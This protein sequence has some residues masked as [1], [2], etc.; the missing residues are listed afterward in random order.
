MGAP[1]NYINIG[2]RYVFAIV[3]KGVFPI[4]REHIIEVRRADVLTAYYTNSVYT[5]RKDTYLI[6]IFT[7]YGGQHLSVQ[8]SK[9]DMLMAYEVLKASGIPAD[10]TI[11]MKP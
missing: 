11:E 5:G 1:R 10:D 6:K 7:D 8:M 3:P 2:E 9:F 4:E